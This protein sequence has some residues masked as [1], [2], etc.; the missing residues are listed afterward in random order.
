E[1]IFRFVAE[2]LCVVGAALLA[3]CFATLQYVIFF[4]ILQDIFRIHSAFSL[5]FLL[6]I[7]AAIALKALLS[8]RMEYDLYNIGKNILK[9]FILSYISVKKDQL[10]EVRLNKKH[11]HVLA[12]LSGIVTIHFLLHM[13]L[14][15][16]SIPENIVSEGIYQAIGPCDEVEQ[17]FSPFGLILY[18]KKY[19][20]VEQQQQKLFDFHCIPGGQLSGTIGS[21]PLMYY[22]ICGTSFL[23][24]TEYIT[25]IWFILTDLLSL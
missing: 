25:F 2:F 1:T 8:S 16:F 21:E 23:E 5:A 18:R 9:S 15:M 12:E 20:C 6:I 3:L 11:I 13:L 17:I 19:F 10:V 14:A 4:H 22:A 7:Y 24:R